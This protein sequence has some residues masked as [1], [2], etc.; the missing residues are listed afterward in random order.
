MPESQFDWDPEN[1]ERAR[2]T[3]PPALFDALWAYLDPAARAQ[4]ATLEVGPGTGQATEALLARGARVTAIELGPRLAAFLTQKF[5]GQPN[6]RVVNAAFE[7]AALPTQVW[8]LVCSATAYHWIP[9]ATRMTRPHALL[10][11]GG[12]LAIID[13]IQVQDA[14]DRDYFERSQPLYARYW[15]N[16]ATFQPSPLPDTVEPPIMAEMRASGLFDD[17]QLWRYRWDQRYDAESYLALVRSYSN[18]YELPPDTRAQFLADLRAFVDAEADATVL[19][20]LVITLVTGRR[21]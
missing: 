19:R 18:T 7:A 4:P 15:P 14:A 17:V 9:A 2:P 13:T 21:R 10:R 12:T 20:P 8:D 1:Y 3:Y 16:Q 5:A 6:L 11:E